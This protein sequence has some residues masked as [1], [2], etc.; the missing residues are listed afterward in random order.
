MPTPMDDAWQQI[1]EGNAVP[2]YLGGFT[3]AEKQT[4]PSG[5]SFVLKPGASYGQASNEYDMNQYLNALGVGVPEAGFYNDSFLS[6]FEDAD[7]FNVNDPAHR[8][9]VRQD[10]SPHAA[11]ANWD[12]LGMVDDNVLIRPDGT[13]TYVDVGGAGPYR[14]G[15]APKGSA[16]GSDISMI[17]RLAN[18]PSHTSRGKTFGG[19]SDKEVG[20]S[21]D[22]Y[23]GQT[24]F[25]DALQF[26][27][28]QQTKNIIQQRVA[29]LAR[30][31]A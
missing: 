26:I 1:A 5:E 12:M 2:S 16:F 22:R 29:D 6:R 13:P 31:V 30:R 23:G 20:Q 15:G 7:R 3:G 21:W 8:S 9:A 18:M 10:I 14:A 4:L 25:E 28:D 24:A 19:L 27:R 17:D 11:I